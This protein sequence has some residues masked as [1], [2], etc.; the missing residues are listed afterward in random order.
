[1]S[2]KALKTL[3]ATAVFISLFGCGS[4]HN[5][6]D[7]TKTCADFGDQ[8]IKLSVLHT[9]DNHGRFWE[10]SK[11]E[12]GMA[13]RKT[14][15]DGVRDEVEKDGGNVLVVSAGD[16]NT[17]IPESDLQDAEP[18]LVGMNLI[19]Y[20]AMTLGNHEFDNPPEVLEKQQEIADF[21]F[22][23]AN[24]Y[25]ED[26]DGSSVR[27]FQPYQVF[28]Y[29]NLRVALVG[30]T[31][32]DT[33]NI[34]N[35]LYVGDYKFTE[36]GAE[37][38]KVIKEL[39]Q[40]DT[41]KDDVVIVLSHLGYYRDAR[42]GSNAPGDVTMVRAQDKGALA[43]VFGGHTHNV[44][45]TNVAGDD[46]KPG[47]ACVPDKENG[48]Y[49][50]QAGSWGKY[51]GRADFEYYNRK[52]HLAR[53][54]LIPVNLRDDDGKVA[55]ELVSPDPTT[56]AILRIYQNQ[57]QKELDKPIAQINDTLN[58]ERASVRFQQTNLGKFIAAAQTA[59]RKADFGIVNSGGIRASIQKGDVTTRGVR[60]V[61]PFS[62]QVYKVT[63]SGAD[64]TRYLSGVATK[65]ID[66]GGYA[67]F[68]NIKMRIDCASEDP[69]QAVTVNEINGGKFD[70]NAM[71]SFS[72]PNFSA[73]G[74]DGYPKLVG[75]DKQFKNAIVFTEGNLVDWEELSDFFK[76]QAGEPTN[77]IDVSPYTPDKNDLVYLNTKDASGNGCKVSD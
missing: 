57:G 42:H 76:S 3:A 20:E 41:D 74:G 22:L 45:C 34:G 77:V 51:V 50:M 55:G 73:A 75:E 27:A 64:L 15:I 1:M 63:M 18:D 11:G 17:G 2:I 24:I 13:V 38:K 9:N 29:Q 69:E 56:E 30:V 60:I 33:K 10:N 71:Y 16:I 7:E 59:S 32:P 68:Y 19:G 39:K 58:G 23:S 62:N 66:S 25:K 40:S 21:P 54:Q 35:P 31:T 70:K 28:T 5:N 36:P 6:S 46:F 4:D 72:I 67:Q 43:A 48:T 37:V 53:Y 44:T 61:E 12:G 52:L 49:I 8:C 14:I 26:D 65:Q 47:D